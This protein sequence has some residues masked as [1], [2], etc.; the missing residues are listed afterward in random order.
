MN[1]HILLKRFFKGFQPFSKRV[2]KYII[3]HFKSYHITRWN[4]SFYK[5]KA[6]I[7]QHKSYHFTQGANFSVLGTAIGAVMI[8]YPHFHHRFFFFFLFSFLIMKIKRNR[9]RSGEKRRSRHVKNRQKVK[10]TSHFTLFIRYWQKK[11][12]ILWR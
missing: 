11:L 3:L 1:I 6:I 12:L 5:L 8:C 9:K 2:T 10:K 7:L 4:D